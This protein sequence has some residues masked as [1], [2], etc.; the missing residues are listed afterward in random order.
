MITEVIPEF[1]FGPHEGDMTSNTELV[2]RLREAAHLVFSTDKYELRGEFGEL[3][4]HL[5]LRGFH[6]TVPL[7]SKIYFKDAVNVAVHGF[8][9]V[10]VTRGDENKLWLGE[11][12]LYATG[13][14]GVESL[15]KDFKTHLKEDYLRQE[16]T[17]ISKRIPDTHPDADEWRDLIHKYT[18]LDKIFSRLV[19]PMVCTYGSGIFG[20]CT[21]ET[22]EYCTNFVEECR[23]LFGAF[24][25]GIG[26]TSTEVILLLLPVPDKDELNRLL[27]G[28]LDAMR[29][30]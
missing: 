30:I 28:R 22:D 11:S 27:Y 8:D 19:I 20:G 1:V 26:N 3:I 23:Q 17:L 13:S 21:E 25:T 12:K 14:Q 10:H 9:G 7:L 29:R 2:S 24:S 4:L 5:L 18:P 6:G 15:V 16:F